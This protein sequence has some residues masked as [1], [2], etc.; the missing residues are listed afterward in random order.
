[1]MKKV[2]V[3]IFIMLGIACLQAKAE[4]FDYDAFNKSLAKDHCLGYVRDGEKEYNRGSY[5]SAISK[6]EAAQRENDRYN[7]EFYSNNE[8]KKKIDDCYY[9]IRNGKTREQM[10]D[11][12]ATKIVDRI[13][14]GGR[15]KDNNTKTQSQTNVT[16]NSKEAEMIQVEY[17]GNNYMAYSSNKY[18]KVAKVTATKDKTVVEFDYYTPSNADSNYYIRIRKD[19]FLKDRNTNNKLYL[20]GVDGITINPEKKHLAAGEMHTFRLIFGPVS[21]GCEE[22]DVVEPDGNWG[23]FRIKCLVKA[24]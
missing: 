3:A 11:D 6:F 5:N 14:G 21:E 20:A 17:M 16:N 18:C 19:T 24:E 10:A 12:T 13:F 1:M 8:L 9:A 7:G 15:K 22:I 23:F 4:K 2:I